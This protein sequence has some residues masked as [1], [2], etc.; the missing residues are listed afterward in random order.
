MSNEGLHREMSD[1]LGKVSTTLGID[2]DLDPDAMGD[3]LEV[4][5]LTAHNLLRPA[6]PVTTYLVGLAIARDPS[7][8]VSEALRRIQAL[9]GSAD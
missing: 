3:V 6:A 8:T 7:L 2:N 4:A 5:A 9:V 1:W